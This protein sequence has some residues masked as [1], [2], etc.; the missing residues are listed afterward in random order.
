MYLKKIASRHI[1]SL[2]KSFMMEEMFQN[3]TLKKKKPCSS[4]CFNPILRI[5]SNLRSYYFEKIIIHKIQIF[6]RR[7]RTPK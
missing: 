5:S 4:F 7:L 2:R 1:P 6:S 3:T